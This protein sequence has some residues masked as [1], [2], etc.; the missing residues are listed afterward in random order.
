[1][2]HVYHL[3]VT[4]EGGGDGGGGGVAGKGA[5]KPVTAV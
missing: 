4:S 1:M 5:A 3:T 2:L